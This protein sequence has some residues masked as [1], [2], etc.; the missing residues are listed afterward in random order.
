MSDPSFTRKVPKGGADFYPTPEWATR[1]LTDYCFPLINHVGKRVWEP[2]C[3]DGAM[4]EVL[5]EKFE[6]I[7]SD[8]YDRGYGQTGVDFLNPGGFDTDKPIDMVITNPPFSKAEDFLHKALSIKS[9]R[10]V[11]LLLRL[12][13]LEGSKRRLT[14]FNG[15]ETQPTDVF[16]FP[17]RITFKPPGVVVKSSGTVAYAWFIWDRDSKNQTHLNWLPRG[18]RR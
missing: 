13:F 8:L 17:E 12:S 5:K 6:V 18:I 16:V 1:A 14:V 7:S 2:A 3:G 4:A 15:T 9:V 11:A 10:L